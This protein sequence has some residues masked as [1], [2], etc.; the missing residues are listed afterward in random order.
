MLSIVRIFALSA[1]LSLLFLNNVAA[2]S[3]MPIFDVA[4]DYEGV[5]TLM[6]T[7]MVSLENQTK[8]VFITTSIDGQHWTALTTF[9]LQD[10]SYKS[11]HQNTPLSVA[12]DD[13]EAI[14][15]QPC[16]RLYL[17]ASTRNAQ[18]QEQLLHNSSLAAQELSALRELVKDVR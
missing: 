8:E 12:L 1:A 10:F 16:E 17:R 4:I 13:F 18:G 6:M 9:S 5:P 2:Q 11:S 14:L 3:R 15:N 7:L